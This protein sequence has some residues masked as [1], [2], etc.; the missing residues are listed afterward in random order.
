MGCNELNLKRL[1]PATIVL[2]CA[3]WV[4]GCS[5]YEKT[6]TNGQI[7]DKSS[8]KGV[9]VFS[10]TRTGQIDYNL[11][12][13]LRGM[14]NGYDQPLPLYHDPDSI[15][16]PVISFTKLNGRLAVMELPQGIYEFYNWEGH[17]SFGRGKSRIRPKTEFSKKFLVKAGEVKYLGNLHLALSRSAFKLLVLDMEDRDLS[18]LHKDNPLITPNS[19]QVSLIR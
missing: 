10:L 6:I 16:G 4:L 19:V 14:E 2:F 8:G 7:P 15:E 18:I 1:L 12:L 3:L 5:G 9:V 17:S 13:N 11:F